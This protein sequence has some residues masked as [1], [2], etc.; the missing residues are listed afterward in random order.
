MPSLSKQVVT[1]TLFLTPYFACA[2]SPST[3]SGQAYPAKPLRLIVPYAAGTGGD[4]AARSVANELV[5]QMG[6]QVVIELRPGANGIIGYEVLARAVPDGYTFGYVA[7]GFSVNPFLYSTLPYDGARDFQP[8]I[9]AT[10]GTY[11]LAVTPTQPIRSV[12]DLIDMA[13]ARPGMLSYGSAGTGGGLHVS[14]E[15]FKYLSGTNIVPVSYKGSQQAITDVIA[16]QVQMVCD[17]MSSILP[18]VTSARV[19]AIGVTALKR[20]PALPEVPTIDEAGIPGYEF[21]SWTG[22]ILPARAPREIMLRLNAE[23]NKALSTPTLSKAISDRGGTVVG[24]TPEQ[25]GKFIRSDI[26]K[27]GKIIKAAGIK[28]Q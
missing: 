2:Q 3:S 14:M 9:F 10:S 16:G 1:A 25:F 12:K 27:W 22:Y 20:A 18:H 26:E 13:R 21:L 11:L 28:P 7:N 5:R 24:G 15:L 17:A 19:R 8:V 23:I 4:I 6:Q